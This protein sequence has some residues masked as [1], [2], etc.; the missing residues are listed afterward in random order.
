MT[1][2]QRIARRAVRRERIKTNL[3][4]LIAKITDLKL[5]DRLQHLLQ[6]DAGDLLA[7]E[8][9]KAHITQMQKKGKTTLSDWTALGVLISDFIAAKKEDETEE[10]E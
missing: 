6:N 5:R 8:A 10:K 3:G 1:R 2:E 4:A 7:L 9:L